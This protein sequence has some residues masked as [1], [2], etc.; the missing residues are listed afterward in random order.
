MFGQLLRFGEVLLILEILS[1]REGL[2]AAH[3]SENS[4]ANVARRKST[5]RIWV[6]RYAMLI[7]HSGNF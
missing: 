5:E 3:G 2:E 1:S 6:L 4:A 7:R